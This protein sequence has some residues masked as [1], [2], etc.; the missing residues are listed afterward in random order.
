MIDPPYVQAEVAMPEGVHV[1]TVLREC[2]TTQLRAGLPVEMFVGEIP[3]PGG[4]GMVHAYMFRPVVGERGGHEA[5]N[6][7]NRYRHPPVWPLARQVTSSNCPEVAIRQALA[8]ACIEFSQ[9]QAAW[10]GAEFA[11][12][13]EARQ[14]VQHFGWTGIPISQMQQA[15]AS[16]FVRIPRGVSRCAIRSL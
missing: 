2:E 4:E 15:C 8:D 13:T 6:G 9:V 3:G 16:R 14:I 12:F 10:L 11:G 5:R 1:F 7:R